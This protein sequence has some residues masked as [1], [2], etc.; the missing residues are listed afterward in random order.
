MVDSMENTGSG[1]LHV[2]GSPLGTMER[3]KMSAQECP[4][5]EEADRFMTLSMSSSE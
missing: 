1:V 4:L 2:S 5:K 3:H